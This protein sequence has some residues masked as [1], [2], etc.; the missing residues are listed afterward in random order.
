MLDYNFDIAMTDD[1]YATIRVVGVGGGGC[2]AVNRMVDGGVQG[3]EFIAV[4]TDH[5]SLLRSR[6][7]QS[8]QIGEKVTRGLGAGAIPEI[9]QKAAEENIAVSY[10]HLDVYKRQ[11]EDFRFLVE[12]K[13]VDRGWGIRWLWKKVRH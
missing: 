1:L 5:Q 11:C 13:Y 8:I 3:I 9:G 4:N 12:L 2:N 7:S 10:T 6:A